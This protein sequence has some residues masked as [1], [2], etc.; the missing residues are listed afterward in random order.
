MPTP[1]VLSLLAY[2]LSLGALACG[3]ND[4]A[5]PNDIPVTQIE[6][7]QGDSQQGPP[8]APLPEPLIVRVTDSTGTPL[9][10]QNVIWAVN[11]GG[12][13]VDPV[14][15]TSNAEGLAFAEWILGPSPGLN[16]VEAQVP[17]SDAITFTAVARTIGGGGGAGGQPAR[18]AQVEGDGQTAKA[19]SPVPVRPAVQVTDS[20]GE[21]VPGVTVTFAVTGGGGSVAG[22]TQNTGSDGI[23]R[24]GRWTLGELAGTNTLEARSG[25][26]AGSPVV[27]T[28]EGT[29]PAPPPAVDRLVYRF[30][31]P[32][33]A[34]KNQPFAVKVAL[35]DKNGDVVPLDGIL[36]YLGLFPEG[37]E[38]PRNQLLNGNRFQSTVAGLATFELSVTEKGSYRLRALT[39]DLPELG[40]HG[41]EP[42]LYSYVFEVK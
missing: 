5:L 33:Q 42:W 19:G 15:A 39:D 11:G 1:R 35:V 13:A 14:T 30:P 37:S 41:P 18:I 12:G 17:G 21:P 9:A 20:A 32:R 8:G 7:V 3:S 27:F 26:L 28:A 31:P 38:T 2:G 34:K 36:I 4:L 29:A 25:S 10:D 40:P 24:V 16:V 23:A 6:M 22:S